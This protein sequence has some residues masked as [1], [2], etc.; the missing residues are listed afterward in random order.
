MQ[1]VIDELLYDTDTAKVIHVE[2]STGRVLYQTPNGRFFMFYSNGEIVPKDEDSA[3]K[4]LSKHNV[5]KYI[6]VFGK[7]K[8][9]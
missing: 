9:A 3:K 2:D 5:A 8:E 6:E 1:R 4:Y 7:P